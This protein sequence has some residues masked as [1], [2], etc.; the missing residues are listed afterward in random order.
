MVASASSITCISSY[1]IT[2]L[3]LRTVHMDL[4]MYK[5]KPD[6]MSG[7]RNVVLRPF[8]ATLTYQFGILALPLLLVGKFP[9]FSS[10]L[11]APA[12]GGALIGRDESQSPVGVKRVEDEMFHATRM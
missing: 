4:I 1:H 11:T 10:T 5:T 6:H 8:I 9:C 7:Y 12:L 2:L 3:S